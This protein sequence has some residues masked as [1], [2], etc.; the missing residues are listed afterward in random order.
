VFS[1]CESLVFRGCESSVGAI[2]RV[3]ASFPWVPVLVGASVS[4]CQFSVGA[5]LQ[6][7]VGASFL[8][9][10]A[11]ISHYSTKKYTA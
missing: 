6:S 3:G 11:L 8:Q 10:L 5:S 9:S 2:V 1:G 4:E 7:S